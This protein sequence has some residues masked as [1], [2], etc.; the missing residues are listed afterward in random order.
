[1]DIFLANDSFPAVRSSGQLSKDTSYICGNSRFF[2]SLN[3]DRLES[4]VGISLSISDCNL[5]S[6][7]FHG[8]IGFIVDNESWETK[9]ESVES[10]RD[11]GA[12]SDTVQ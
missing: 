11:F 3:R 5:D 7:L 12:N 2:L 6:V 9:L 10:V 4:S 8:G 1:L